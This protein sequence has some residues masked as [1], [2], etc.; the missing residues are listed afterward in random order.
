MASQNVHCEKTHQSLAALVA[1][2]DRACDE[3]EANAQFIS[4]QLNS[5]N[6]RLAPCE[7]YYSRLNNPPEDDPYHRFFE[8]LDYMIHKYLAKVYKGFKKLG[9]VN[10]GLPVQFGPQK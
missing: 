10:F 5:I 9:I 8:K 4:A 1:S 2:L 3:Q 7:T 6:S